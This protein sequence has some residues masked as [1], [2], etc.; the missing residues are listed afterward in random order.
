[1]LVAG[2]NA[3]VEERRQLAIDRTSRIED[4]GIHLD[5]AAD[6]VE[7][8]RRILRIEREAERAARIELGSDRGQTAV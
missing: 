1:M 6:A 4:C 8:F 7:R 2:R 3:S 5:D